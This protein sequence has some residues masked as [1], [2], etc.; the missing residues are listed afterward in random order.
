MIKP[1]DSTVT[2]FDEIL[3]YYTTENG[4]CTDESEAGNFF[5]K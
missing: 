4:R 3:L 5:H 2:F 1:D